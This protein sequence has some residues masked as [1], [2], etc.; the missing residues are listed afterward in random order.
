MFEIRNKVMAQMDDVLHPHIP[1]NVNPDNWLHDVEC[2]I[3]SIPELAIVDR[4]AKL[5]KLYEMLIEHGTPHFEE[6][7][8][9][10]TNYVKEVKDV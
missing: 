9:L 8:M 2:A 1:K 10:K 4:E 5:P 3:L 6:V 7:D